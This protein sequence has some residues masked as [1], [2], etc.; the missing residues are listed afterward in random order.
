[1]NSGITDFST[2]DH[3]GEYLNINIFGKKKFKGTGLRWGYR[4]FVLAN[5]YT[6]K[7]GT[8]AADT[9][10]DWD[11]A[12]A[13]AEDFTK[14]EPVEFHTLNLLRVIKTLNFVADEEFKPTLLASIALDFDLEK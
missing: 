14:T 6:A 12:K 13:E 3:K 5:I 10:S 9:F 2:A 11:L 7:N 1:M 8:A 4:Y